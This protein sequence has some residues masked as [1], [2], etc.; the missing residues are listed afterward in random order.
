MEA[1]HLV[2]EESAGVEI[3]TL[4][5]SLRGL[6]S[7]AEQVE[8]YERCD[9]AGNLAR[10]QTMVEQ[11]H[12]DI[13]RLKEQIKTNKAALLKAKE[14]AVEKQTLLR[15][16]DDVINYREK[17]DQI[18]QKGHEMEELQ[19]QLEATPGL[20]SNPSLSDPRRN[21]HEKL[22]EA[23]R[24]MEAK[25]MKQMNISGQIDGQML[26]C[27][28]D[29]KREE[30]D[31]AHY[32]NA[33]DEYREY[34]IKVIKNG[35]SSSHSHS[36]S[37]SHLSPHLSSPLLTSPRL[38]SHLSSSSGQDDGDG[39][40]RPAEV[41]RRARQ[42]AHRLPREEDEGGRRHHRL[43]RSRSCSHPLEH[44]LTFSSPPSSLRSTTSSP[45]SGSRRTRARTS[46]PSRSARARRDRP[47]S[48]TT[49]ACSCTRATPSSTCAGGAPRGRR[50]PRA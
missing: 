39:V 4:Q 16:M 1:A 50:C 46:T 43:T 32:K 45:S 29:L 22:G 2:A 19:A 47:R 49:T 14:G 48:R 44:P 11:R 36:H 15:N 28:E 37:H 35:L 25:Y 30:G 20:A 9:E 42:S 7:I 5:E 24:E 18:E 38:T 34:L 21:P 13:E 3:A 23:L 10:L 6:K 26:Q 31:L 27:K 12:A 33:D 17:K 40:L 41:Q 8:R